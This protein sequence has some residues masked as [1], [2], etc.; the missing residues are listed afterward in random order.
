MAIWNRALRGA[1]FI[2]IALAAAAVPSVFKIG[3]AIEPSIGDGVYSVVRTWDLTI[4]GIAAP[5][6]LEGSD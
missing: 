3:D 4:T 6:V 5:S 2:C 1:L